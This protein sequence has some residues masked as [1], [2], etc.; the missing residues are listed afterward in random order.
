M[1]YGHFDDVRREYVI[2]RPDTPLPWINYLGSEDVLRDH[3]EHG[4]RVLLLPRRPAAPA[5]P[6]SLQQRAARPRR[7][8]PLP[9]RRRLRRL[10][11]PQLA[12]DPA[13]P[14]GLRLPPRPRLHRSSPRATR[15]SAPRRSTSSPTARPSRSGGSGSPTSGPSRRSISLFSS[16]EFCL[17]DA[18]DDATNFQ[19]NYSIGE[20]EVEDGVIY[21]TTE[22]RERRDHFAYFACSEPLAGFDTQRDAF[23]G[24]YRGWDR[25]IAVERGAASNSIA[26]GW[27]PSGSHHVRLELGPGET[28]EV[29]FVLGYA[30]NPR[31]AKFDPP[32]SQTIDKRRVRPTIARY[33][34]AR[35]GRRGVRGAAGQLG[36]PAWDPPRSG[37]GTSTSTGWSTS[38]TPT[39]AWS[40]STCRARPPSTNPGIGRGMGFRDSDPG[41][42]GLRPHG[43]GA[44]PR[45][46]PRHGRD[47]AADRRRLP[48]VPAAHQARQR[49]GRLRLQRRPA[50]L[51]LAV[52]AYLKETGDASILDEAVPYDNQPGTETAALRA[53]PA[54]H[55]VHAGAARPAR[56]AAHR[57]RRL[58]RLPE[59]QLLLGDARRVVPDDRA[60]RGRGR[61]VGVHRRP[62]RAARRASWPRS[63]SA[64]ATPRRRRAGDRPRRR[65]R[66]AVDRARLGRRVV[67][68]RLRLLRRPCRLGRERRGPDLHRAAGHLRHGRH[69]P[70]RRAGAPG[71]RPPSASAWR[72][73][74]GS[75]CSSRPSRATTSTSARSRPTRR[76]T[77]RTPAS[78]ATRTRG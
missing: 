11:E 50:W 7:P 74:T 75:S 1:R 39:S 54:V 8:V 16:I 6:L 65:W 14:R 64:A 31:D 60:P 24:P 17:W 77:R 35:R 34:A 40:R 45:A 69:R 23:L 32:G 76:A 42:A 3:L 20:V 49:R 46:A 55:R 27:Q 9:P 52:A 10:L 66:D 62:V 78:S 43:P 63:P 58:E 72:R 68:A 70:R 37:P 41:P 21:H 12:A 53:S 57:P 71:A 36:R 13:R 47:A 56:P 44:R 25:P 28:K 26:H 15:A 4:G 59:P 48:P 5:D 22:Y 18:Q 67:P 19:R 29:I 38:G 2:T 33:L 73:R 61:R 51:V 30:E